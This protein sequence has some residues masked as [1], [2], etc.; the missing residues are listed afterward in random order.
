MTYQK[1]YVV[2]ENDDSFPHGLYF[3]GAQMSKEMADYHVNMLIAHTKDKNKIHPFT[4]FGIE[5]Y[6]EKDM[7]NFIHDFKKEHPHVKTTN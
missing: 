2:A 3:Y 4:I 7:V 5:L 1:I 6:T